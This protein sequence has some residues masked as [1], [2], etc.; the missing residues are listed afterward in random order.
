M[1]LGKIDDIAAFFKVIDECRDRVELLTGEGDRLNLK[2]KVSQ[3]ASMTQI[4]AHQDELHL[5][6]SAS[7]PDDLKKINSFLMEH[8]N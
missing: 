6:I 4:F 2:S 5:E 8:E 3:F 1:K 7:D